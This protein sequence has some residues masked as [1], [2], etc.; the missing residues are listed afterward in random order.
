MFAAL[1]PVTLCHAQQSSIVKLT[2]EKK[3]GA[4]DGR[5]MATVKGPAKVKGKVVITEKTGRIATQAIQAWIV[6]D[7]QG[8]LLLLSPEK[9]GLPSRLRYYELDAGKGRLLGHLPFQEATIAERKPANDQ[10]AFALSG[11]DPVSKQPVIFAGDTHAIHAH[12][13]G[14]SQP[15]FSADSLSYQTPGGPQTITMADLVALNY[16]T[17]VYAPPKNEANPAY[18][19]FL[20]S[21]DS[22]TISSTGE[23]ER[24]RWIKAGP[25]FQVTSAKGATAVWPQ[26]ELQPVTGI[27][28][29]DRITVRLLQPLSSRTAKAGME[30]KAVSITPA[31][32]NGSILIPQDSEFSGKI[33]EAHGVGW[34]IKHES[35]ALTLH[36]D[37]AKLPDGRTLAIDARVF[38]VENSQESVTAKGK[39]QGIRSTGTLG[40]SA[41][42]KISSLAQIDPVAYL[43]LGASGPA[44]LGFAEPEILYNAGTELTIEFH[45]PVITAQTYPPRV[46]RMDLSG[47]RQ[48]D[49]DTL[50]KALPYR[51]KTEGTNKVSDITNLIFIGKASSLRRAF[52]AAGWVPSDELNAAS[53]FQ[54]VKTLTGNQKYTQAP[55]ST[56]LL[57]EQKPLFTLSKTTN[58]FSSRH[59]IRVFGTSETWDGKTVLTASSTQDIGIAFS[60]KQKTFIH[61]IDQYLDNERS[62]VTN[63]LEFTGC[64]DSIDLA[65]RSWVPMDAYN[66]TGDRLRTDGRAAVLVINDCADPH[67]TPTTPA[68]RAGLFQRSERN[69]ALT[70]KDQ[71]YRGNVVYQGISGGMKIHSYLAQQGE[72]P[73]D[74]GNWRKS[75]AS[76]TEYKVAGS[77][78]HLSR[79]KGLWSSTAAEG[80]NELDAA[81]RA[82]ILS[83]KWDPPRFEIALNLG[84]S[85][86]RNNFLETT[87]VELSTDEQGQPNYLLG[88]GDA[89]FDGWAA[90]VS[91]TLNT[92]NWIS[93]EFS[94]MRQQT[95]FD[96]VEITIGVTADPT[97]GT[98]DTTD[99]R[100]VGLVTR[101]AAY[102]TVLNFRPRRSRWRPYISAGPVFQLLSLSN[103]PLKKPSGYFRLGLTNIGLVKAAFDFGS[104]APLNGGG[105]FQLGVQYG[106]GIKYRV[107]PR[108]TMRA[109][110]GETFTQNPTIIRDSY[111]GY[112]PD[113]LDD[114]YTTTVTNAKPPSKFV[115]QRA[116]VGF[117]FTF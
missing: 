4:L 3:P 20:P 101:R 117:A 110:F 105:I 65:P 29:T 47:E 115:Q 86:Y 9:K 79:R 38:K 102:N 45:T 106:G 74:E 81:A 54:T 33:I 34:G 41:E 11:S 70:I 59:H 97:T 58:T 61:V 21:G 69:T 24:G 72:L 2:V 36:F 6:L 73:E 19:E 95:K 98:T 50:V 67:S 91:L 51:T 30:V 88:L 116:T 22:L 46:P 109:D 48:S 32:A 13:D 76:G 1:L 89:V 52:E 40:N 27:P 112:I 104:V 43:F 68:E 78:P 64:V 82:R 62:K 5:A 113:G 103:A 25:N 83:H 53:T 12:I 100:I 56:L 39:I 60:A 84:Y 55:M 17:G 96:L 85:K 108:L 7:G 18:L 14:A 28:A 63:D 114:S 94:Y 66:S 92:N 10:W 16:Q 37:T 49:F 35:A 44:V 42:N 107:L 80:Q 99:A 31:L 71:L 111:I 8:A 77:G 15:Q 75:D 57:D 93:N 26:A 23:V 87:V 90:G